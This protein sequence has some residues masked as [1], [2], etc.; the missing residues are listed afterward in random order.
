MRSFAPKESRSSAPQLARRRRRHMP[1]GGLAACAAS[2]STGCS[3]S[4][5]NTWN[6]RFAPTRP[7]T[8]NIGRTAR[9]RS[10]RRSRSHHPSIA[11][12]ACRASTAGIASAAC[13][14][15][16][17]SRHKQIAK[18]PCPNADAQ[19]QRRFPIPGH[20]DL[21]AP[22]EQ[23]RQSA[24]ANACLLASPARPPPRET[25]SFRH[26]HA[27]VTTPFHRTAFSSAV[28]PLARPQAS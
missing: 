5:A 22:F 2:V 21:A 24:A 9:S 17:N 7:I 8:T 27:A 12:R 20:A 16:T 1:N 13:S 11:G 10:T 4:D 3:S 6:E 15:S 26:P 18:H 19:G 28:S 25:P 14:T 23:P